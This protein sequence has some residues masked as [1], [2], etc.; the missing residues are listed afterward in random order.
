MSKDQN[1]AS[2]FEKN[3]QDISVKEPH[4][5]DW[6]NLTEVAQWIALAATSGVIGSAAYEL[7]K[8][9]KRRFG[10]SRL[11]ELEDKVNE[12]IEASNEDLVSR[13]R[14]LFKEFE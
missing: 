5:L 8:G 7:L 4:L 6:G 2:S 3:D 1:Q 14:K 13:I 11:K 12:I 9:I 10:R